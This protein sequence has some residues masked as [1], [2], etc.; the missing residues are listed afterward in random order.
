VVVLSWMF[1]AGVGDVRLSQLW[2]DGL[3]GLGR[4]ESSGPPSGK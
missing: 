1:V 3:H 4:R 2:A